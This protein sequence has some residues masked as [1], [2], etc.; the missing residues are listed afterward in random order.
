MRLFKSFKSVMVSSGILAVVCFCIGI[1]ISYIYSVPAGASIVIV[2][3]C[4][5][6][7]FFL[8]QKLKL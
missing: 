1:T 6:I 3:L 8:I 7:V 5:F 2:N 4:V